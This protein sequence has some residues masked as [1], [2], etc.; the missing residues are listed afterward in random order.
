M[1]QKP[2]KCTSFF[3]SIMKNKTVQEIFTGNRDI[4]SWYALHGK[5][6]QIIYPVRCCIY[7]K[8]YTKKWR[9]DFATP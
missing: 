4:V 8:I 7:E 5:L 1:N 3:R 6:V 9:V 2:R